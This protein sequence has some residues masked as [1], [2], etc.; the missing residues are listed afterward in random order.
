MERCIG[1]NEMKEP[2]DG[3]LMGLQRRDGVE[4]K[5]NGVDLCYGPQERIQCHHLTRILE[6]VGWT[7]Q[8]INPK[9]QQSF[10]PKM[11]RV[12]G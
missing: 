4:T 6:R 7:L 9:Q 5:A 3:V 8:E 12:S 2:G 11:R 10:P 1:D